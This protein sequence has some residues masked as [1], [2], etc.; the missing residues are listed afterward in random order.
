MMEYV[1]HAACRRRRP[2]TSPGEILAW[3]QEQ[4]ETFGKTPLSH[5]EITKAYPADII[6]FLRRSRPTTVQS[7]LGN[8]ITSTTLLITVVLTSV[9]CNELLELVNKWYL[10]HCYCSDVECNEAGLAADISAVMW[11]AMRLV[12]LMTLVQ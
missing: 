6:A 11:S 8:S 12:W 5:K 10:L 7:R 3:R 2:R 4:R 1:K 9:F